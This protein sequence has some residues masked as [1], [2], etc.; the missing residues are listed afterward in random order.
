MVMGCLRLASSDP[1]VSKMNESWT[2]YETLGFEI[3]LI[4]L[5]VFNVL[6]TRQWTPAIFSLLMSLFLFVGIFFERRLNSKLEYLSREIDYS[7]AESLCHSFIPRIDLLENESN[8]YV[9]IAEWLYEKEEVPI[10]Y[11]RGESKFF[12]LSNIGLSH[13]DII[14]KRAREKDQMKKRK[15]TTID[16]SAPASKMLKLAQ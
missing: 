12:D 13:K 14:R 9:Y 3:P 5:T 10:Y 11:Y 8:P 1:T 15:I 7:K 16:E 6:L 2:M 4:C